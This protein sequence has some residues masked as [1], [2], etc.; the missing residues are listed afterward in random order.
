MIEIS[1]HADVRDYREKPLLGL[2]RR[3]AACVAAAATVAIGLGAALV[4]V[5]GMRLEDAA[6]PVM[7]AC[8]PVWLLGFWSPLGL[9]AEDY[10]AAWARHRLG[11][12]R[13]PNEVARPADRGARRMRRRHGAARRP[14][15]GE[16][17]LGRPASRGELRRAR[18]AQGVHRG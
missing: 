13:V 17:L 16:E 18:R 4:H 11:R 10:L 6:W 1:V 5:W 14:A 3:K 12:N 15:R 9:P 8:V 7:G 2:S